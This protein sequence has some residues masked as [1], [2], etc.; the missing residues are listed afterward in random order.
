VSEVASESLDYPLV[1]AEYFLGLRGAGLILS[2]LDQELVS[3]WERRGLPAAV[4]CRGLRHGIEHLAAEGAPRPPR[5]LRAL[6]GFVEEEWRG[7]RSGRVGDGPAP[8]GEAQAAARRLETARERLADA[9][10]GATGGRREAYRAAWRALL[11]AEAYPGTPLERASAAI[12]AADA[13]LIATWLRSLPRPERAALGARVRLL[14]GARHRG[15]SP[16]AHR[17]TLRAHLLDLALA[18]GLT[19]LRGSV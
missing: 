7:Y 14:G 5:S 18:A 15:T 6:R 17:E 13:R 16:R 1:V 12:A 9:A 3:E 19:P 10:R 2:P 4:V 11:A 8:P